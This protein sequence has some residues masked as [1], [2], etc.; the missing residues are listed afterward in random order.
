MHKDIPIKYHLDEFNKIILDLRNIDVKIDDEDQAMIM[1]C[2]LPSFE[3]FV[4]TI[5]IN[6]EKHIDRL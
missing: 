3:H 6:L 2:C 1:M 5:W 4:N